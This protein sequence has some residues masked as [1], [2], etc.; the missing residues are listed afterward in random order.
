[1]D[2]KTNENEGSRMNGRKNQVSPELEKRLQEFRIWAMTLG[3]YSMST[4]KRTVRR[5]RSF[6][7]LLDIEHPDQEKILNFFA[8]Q[9]EKGVKSHSI[10]N[11]RKDLEAWFRFIHIDMELPKLKEAP[12]PDP[13]IPTDEE[14]KRIL[15]A[16]GS[17]SSRKEINLRNSII[18]HIA[19][20][21]GARIGEIVRINVDDVLDNGIRIRSEKGEADRVVGLPDKIMNDVRKYISEYRPNT[22]TTGLFTTP[23]GRMT[24]DYMRNLARR[25]GAFSGVK[26]FHWHAARHWCATSLLKGFMGAKPV[27]IRMVQIHLGHKSLKTTQRYTHVSQQEVAEVVRSRMGEIFQGGNEMIGND[28]KNESEYKSYGADRIRT[29]DH[30]VMSQALYLA[31]LQPLKKANVKISLK[32]FQWCNSFPVKYTHFVRFLLTSPYFNI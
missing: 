18:A 16:A 14:V 3:G 29:N 6:S 8:R 15:K 21:G 26:K 23:Y 12:S 10:N 32:L 27:D 5:L 2:M 24:Y 11:Q 30:L 25:I 31:K 28:E 22:D 20:F 1:M 19:F 4:V 13:W 7:Q 9:I 17:M